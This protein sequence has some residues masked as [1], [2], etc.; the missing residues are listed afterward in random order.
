MARIAIT[1]D[2]MAEDGGE[3]DAKPSGGGGG[4]PSGKFIE[5][6]KEEG[7]KKL[8]NPD[9]GNNVKLKSLNGPKG[10][11]VVRKLFEKWLDDQKKDQKGKPKDKA[12]E[13]DQKEK[14]KAEEEKP[15]K[16]EAPKAKFPTP[17]LK[18]DRYKGKLKATSYISLSTKI[19]PNR[20]PSENTVKAIQAF[21]KATGKKL[22]EE[23]IADMIGTSVLTSGTGTYNMDLSN[24]KDGLRISSYGPHVKAMERYLKVDDKGEPYIYNDTLMLEDDAPKGLGTKIFANEVAQ[25]K[26]AG[27]KS[28]KCSAFRDKERPEWVGYKVWPKLGYD[29]D[30]PFKGEGTDTCP[31]LSKEIKGKLD[32]AGFKEPYKVSHLYQVEGGQEWWGEECPSMLLLT[33][34]TTLYP[35]RF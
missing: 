27:I 2:K 23:S 21:T 26:A 33:P 12:K 24:T 13:E 32:K 20:R 11:E 31:P 17:G 16:K 7:D 4:K 6:M 35:C 30:I 3:E 19:D 22:T 5:F 34:L 28:I 14:G 29:G 18:K 15:E 9:T 25:A 1:I 8:R 10:K